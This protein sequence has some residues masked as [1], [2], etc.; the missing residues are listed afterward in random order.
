MG[1]GI[2][3]RVGIFLQVA[4][5]VTCMG[6]LTGCAG[7]I[8]VGG[9]SVSL[10]SGG[11]AAKAGREMYDTMIAEGAAY[12]DKP[13]QDYVSRIG[14]SLVANTEDPNAIFTFTVLDSPNINAF[15]TPGGFIYVN[16][17]LMA[18]L[19]S[20]AELAGVL[21]HEIAHITRD[22][23]SR[24]QTANVTNSVL[25]AMAYV[26]TGSSD[27]AE[28]SNMAGT[29]LVRGYGRD[30]EL[31]AD[32]YGA[33][34][35]HKTGYDADALLEVI[36]VLKNQEQFQ[37]V[38]AK[39]SGKKVSSY[40]GL[41]ATH[42]RNDARLQLVIS[43]ASTLEQDAENPIRPGEFRQFMEGLVWGASTQGLRAEDRY[44][45]NKLA[46]TLVRPEGWTVIPS[47]KAIV[48]SSADGS[49]SLTVT[50]RKLDHALTPQQVL[51]QNASGELSSGMELEQSGLKGYTAV[52]ANGSAARR[53]AVIDYK[54]L[55]YLFEGEGA[56]FS[57]ADATLLQVVKSF[58]PTHPKEQ[59]AGAPA[60]IHYI[61]VPRG[62]TLETLAGGVRIPD[63]QSQLRL[64]NGF[65]PRGEPRIGDWIKVIK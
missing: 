25:A 57:T 31:E 51:E 46:F 29:A 43:T 18:Y 16:R 33:R 37:R 2:I 23:S 30:H 32:E 39:S 56:N 26:I 11:S 1:L 22:H 13:L 35:M 62:A 12:D 65:Y 10:P 59:K 63:A 38:K 6:L 4:S 3:Q 64:L 54:S 49:A 48:A 7:N 9:A 41:Y 61:Q 40:H 19:D 5:I 60:Y 50:I 55:S 53:V 14:Q 44:Y 36:G 45:H 47:S 58:R 52:A 17:G 27:V 28:A 20:E 24:Q 15:A 34:Y 21:G 8:T 42:P